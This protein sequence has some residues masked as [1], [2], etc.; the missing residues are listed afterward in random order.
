MLDIPI[1]LVCLGATYAYARYLQDGLVRHS[2]A[3]ALLASAAML[4]KG[5]GACLALLPPLAVLF[6]RRFDLL[7]RPSFWVPVPIVAVL[8]G[9]WYM[10][11]YGMVAAGFRYG[12]G[13]NYVAHATVG[14]SAFLFD[15]VG[16]AVLAAASIGVGATIAR[17]WKHRA[18]PVQSAA[19]AFLFAD[20]IFQSVAPADIQARY[21]APLLP[22]LLLLA[23]DGVAVT[24]GC[25]SRQFRWRMPAA[26]AGLALLLTLTVVAAATNVAVKQSRGFMAV[27]PQVWQMLPANNR[28][29]LIA[30]NGHGEAA[31]LAAL[32]MFDP[33][34]PSL[35]AIRG[36]RLLGGGGYNTQD[37]VPRFET[38]E[39]VMA[40]IDD[41]AIPLVLFRP[42]SSDST[43]W[44]H[45]DQV[46]EAARLDPVRWQELFRVTSVDPAVVLFGIRGNENKPLEAKRLMTL[47]APKSLGAA[48]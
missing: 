2:V 31:A 19:C 39:Q 26:E 20:W 34:R 40:A 24:A 27:A 22:P 16:P 29:V 44:L 7:R 18:A 45:V 25:L 42:N 46:A 1:A 38:A 21:L 15:S 3:F 33:H 5:N 43:P 28:A 14:N 17:A 6:A 11:T 47:S 37:Y 30:T 23:A 10:L 13:W 48:E 36:S 32:A 12:W 4:I 9:P 8:V 41:Y 35:F